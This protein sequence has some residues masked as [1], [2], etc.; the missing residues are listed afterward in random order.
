VTLAEK[1]IRIK[2]VG[3]LTDAEVATAAG[4]SPV[5]VRFIVRT[6]ENPKLNRVW[7]RLERF[8][9]VNSAVKCRADLRFI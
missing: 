8:C 5:T 7:E 1:L 4:V 3:H 2:T 6:G 9:E